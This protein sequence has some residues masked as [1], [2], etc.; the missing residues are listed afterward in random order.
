MQKDINQPSGQDPV[1]A[2]P[3]RRMYVLELVGF[4]FMALVL[5]ALSMGP[6]GLLARKGLCP[7][8]IGLAYEPLVSFSRAVPPLE[9]ALGWYLKFWGIYLGLIP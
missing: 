4:A 2:V 1:A 9:T 5:Y 7:N 3:H 6:M 8:Q